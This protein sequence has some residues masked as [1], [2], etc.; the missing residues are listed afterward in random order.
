M[1]DIN[2]GKSWN[3]IKDLL[4]LKLCNANTHKSCF[5][6]IQQ[7]EKESLAGYVHQFKTDAKRC[8]FTNDAATI[9]IFIK[10]LKNAHSLATLS[11]KRD[12]KC[13]LM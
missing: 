8:Y 13:S 10:R 12:H 1:E 7:W 4:W 2:S 9:R 5:M 3:K 11:V 6:E